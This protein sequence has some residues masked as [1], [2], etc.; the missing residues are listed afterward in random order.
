MGVL[1][2]EDRK[3]LLAVARRSIEL[4]LVNSPSKP[5][6]TKSEVMLQS[7]GVFVTLR[8]EGEL[9]GCI[10]YVEGRSPLGEAVEEMAVRSA[11]HD[12]R[13][14]PLTKEE[15]SK[16]SIEISVLSPLEKL[17]SVE[18]IV[19]GLH[20]LMIESDAYRGLLLPH[21]AVEHGWN[22]EEFLSQT[23]VKAGLPQSAWKLSSTRILT[24]TTETF[25]DD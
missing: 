22:A 4:E 6:P 25:S 21:V 12:P 7:T 19:I 24:F 17:D 11:F 14:P 16:I 13:F 5:S 1:T 2:L 18:A 15:F 10:G 3:A 20:G 23:C 9:R 8:I